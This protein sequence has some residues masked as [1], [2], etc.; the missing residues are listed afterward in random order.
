MST[1]TIIISRFTTFMSCKETD[2][3]KNYVRPFVYQC[4]VACRGQFIIALAFGIRSVNIR[5]L[6]KN[7]GE[8]VVILNPD[9][10]RHL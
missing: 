10:R 7:A 3:H 1:N 8:I 2:G 4:F 9:H 6:F 5:F